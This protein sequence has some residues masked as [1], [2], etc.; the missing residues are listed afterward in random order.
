M[1][2]NNPCIEVLYHM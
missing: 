1:L 2:Y